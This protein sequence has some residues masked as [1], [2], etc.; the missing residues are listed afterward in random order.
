M[1]ST[2]HNSKYPPDGVTLAMQDEIIRIATLRLR[3]PLSPEIISMIRINRWSYMGLESIID[4]IKTL[5]VH[6]IEN[7]LSDLK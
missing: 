2:D 3:R 7:Y 4:N 5:E 1:S 6:E